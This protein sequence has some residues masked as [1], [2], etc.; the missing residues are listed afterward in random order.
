MAR[1]LKNVALSALLT[2][3]SLAAADCPIPELPQKLTLTEALFSWST[4][5]KLDSDSGSFGT[6]TAEVLSWSDTFNYTDA[7]GNPIATA[8]TDL[9]SWGVHIDVTDCEGKKIGELKEQIL[10]SLFSWSST[11]E[12]ND[13]QGNLIARSEKTEWLGTEFNLY[14]AEGNHLVKISRP[15]ASLLRDNWSIEFSKPGSIDPRLIVT[16]GAFKTLVDNRRQDEEE[17]KKKEEEYET[18]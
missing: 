10:K 2:L 3:S 9:F 14:D 13:A 8:K 12:I 4:T 18:R 15:W 16:I 6:V 7:K 5:L 1:L 17:E 11:Y